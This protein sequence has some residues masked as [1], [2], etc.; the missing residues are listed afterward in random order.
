MDKYLSFE[1]KIRKAFSEEVLRLCKERNVEKLEI[2]DENYMFTLDD[3]RYLLYLKNT[4][5]IEDNNGYLY[6]LSELN[7]DD[8][9][10]LLDD[11]KKITEKK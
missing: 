9:C 4:G 6:P 8:T 11:I 5:D 7:M 2:T 3:N 1:N 10:F